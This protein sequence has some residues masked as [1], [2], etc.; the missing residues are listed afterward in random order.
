MKGLKR[1]LF[2]LASF[3]TLLLAFSTHP[4]SARDDADW[5][6][7]PLG[8]YVDCQDSCRDCQKSCQQNVPAGSKQS[9][10]I[11]ACTAAAASCCGANGKNPPSYTGCTCQ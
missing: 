4:A 3:T 7:S 9:D 5:K 8:S 6:A 10:S 1:T 11:R 2:A